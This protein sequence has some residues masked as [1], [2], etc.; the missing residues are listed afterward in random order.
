MAQHPN[1]DQRRDP[2]TVDQVVEGSSTFAHPTTNGSKSLIINYRLQMRGR[3]FYV[4]RYLCA[5]WKPF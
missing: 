2:L 1:R 5:I 3:L 4:N